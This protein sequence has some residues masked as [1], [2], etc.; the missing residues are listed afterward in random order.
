MSEIVGMIA[1]HTFDAKG[2]I[3]AC[4][5][6]PVTEEELADRKAGYAIWPAKCGKVPQ[7]PSEGPADSS[8]S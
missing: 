6:G 1:T 3:V 8:T 7:T 4:A 5:E 2:N